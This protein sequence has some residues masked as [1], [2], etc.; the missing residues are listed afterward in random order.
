MLGPAVAIVNVSG[1]G[2]HGRRAD[3]ALVDDL[4]TGQGAAKVELKIP[5]AL[6]QTNEAT[7]VPLGWYLSSTA[8]AALDAL[9]RTRSSCW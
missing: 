6:D 3:G 9:V 8:R 1:V 7:L 5:C 4:V 2:A